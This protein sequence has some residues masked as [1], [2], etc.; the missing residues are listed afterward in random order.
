ML[1]YTFT[2]KNIFFPE[3]CF[4][5]PISEQKF[6]VREILWKNCGISYKGK[7]FK[8]WFTFASEGLVEPVGEMGVLQQLFFV[9]VWQNQIGCPQFFDHAF[10]AAPPNC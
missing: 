2:E 6:T 4:A 9:C 3:T 5:Y 8:I 10:A 7:S 1:L